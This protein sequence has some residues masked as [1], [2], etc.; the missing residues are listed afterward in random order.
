MMGARAER[1]RVDTSVLSRRR[2]A[3]R[4]VERKMTAVEI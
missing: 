3:S 4:C 2:A 1:V